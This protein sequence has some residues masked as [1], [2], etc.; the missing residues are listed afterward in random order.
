MNHHKQFVRE[1]FTLIEAL[2]YL[3]LFSLIMGGTL[4]A[5]YNLAQADGQS[6]TEAML[7]NEGDFVL[8]KI[9]WA[10]SG[11]TSIV[12]PALGQAGAALSVNKIVSFDS[13]GNPVTIPL[14]FSL[15]QSG[16]VLQ[17]AENGASPEP[18]TNANV[19]VSNL[20]FYYALDSGIGGSIQ[21]IGTRFTLS[22]RTP[23]GRLLSQDFA[24]TSTLSQ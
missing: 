21:S 18:L 3:A 12:A 2:I 23:Q 1:G 22:A 7:Q 4:A 5:A 15:D 20:S 16:T 8:A 10:E 14:V 19:T 13:S 9:A 6:S 24:A 17:V 11:V